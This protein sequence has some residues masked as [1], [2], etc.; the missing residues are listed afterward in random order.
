MREKE[1]AVSKVR[2][3]AVERERHLEDKLR[4]VQGVLE[5]EQLKVRQLDWSNQDLTRDKDAIIEK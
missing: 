2:E 1:A 5:E 3:A 4:N